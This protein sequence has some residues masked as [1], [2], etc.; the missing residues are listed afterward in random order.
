MTDML[1]TVASGFEAVTKNRELR[2]LKPEGDTKS[3]SEAQLEATVAAVGGLAR[4][5]GTLLY[6]HMQ[7]LR[8]FS[9]WDHAGPIFSTVVVTIK[10]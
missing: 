3:S 4:A 5:V 1:E 9:M 2:S 6:S 7:M 8:S 10:G